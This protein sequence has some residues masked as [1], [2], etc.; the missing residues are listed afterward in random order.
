MFIY[1]DGPNYGYCD[2]I[3]YPK[4]DGVPEY[5]Y[6]PGSCGGETFQ[7]SYHCVSIQHDAF[8]EP[9]TYITNNTLGGQKITSQKPN[10]GKWHPHAQVCIKHTLKC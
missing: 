5:M 1:K 6:Y 4:M 7:G 9:L 2:D 10:R 8:A 3:W